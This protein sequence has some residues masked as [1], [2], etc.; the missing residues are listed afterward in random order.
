[1]QVIKIKLKSSVCCLQASFH[2]TQP[3]RISLLQ[4]QVE[5]TRLE[6][7]SCTLILSL[8]QKSQPASMARLEMCVLL[9]MCERTV[10]PSD[11]LA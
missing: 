1:M 5:G 3:L 9:C 6:L 4:L 7:F 8:S 2:T 10:V 11:I